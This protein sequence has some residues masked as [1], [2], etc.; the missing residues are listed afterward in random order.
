MILII[1]S[2]MAHSPVGLS[3]HC[4]SNSVL[5]DALKIQ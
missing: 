3:A 2:A 1:D 5:T 4:A